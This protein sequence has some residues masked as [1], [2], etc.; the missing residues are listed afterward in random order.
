MIAKYKIDYGIKFHGHIQAHH[1]LTNDPVA[2]TWKAPFSL[3]NRWMREK[4]EADD[5]GNSRRG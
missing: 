3:R 5:N 4:G 2:S 1:Y